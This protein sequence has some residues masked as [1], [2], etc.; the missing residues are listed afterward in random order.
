MTPPATPLLI[1]LDM[2]MTGL[3]PERDRILE[4]ATIVTDGEL[5]VVAKGPSLVVHQPQS[6]LDGMDE[7]NVSHHTRSGLLDA[8]RQSEVDTA[9][10]EAQTLDFLRRHTNAGE[11]PLCGNSVWQDRRFMA[12]H[13]PALEAHF[14]YRLVDVS[15]ISELAKRWYPDLVTRKPDKQ[16]LHRAMDDILEAVEEL[17]WYRR[18]LFPAAAGDNGSPGS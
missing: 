9:C 13:M 15:T 10:A 6:V 3:N 2:E 1:W 7:W 16:S 14:H 11:S 8:T 5:S 4:I 12:R 18:H 17:A